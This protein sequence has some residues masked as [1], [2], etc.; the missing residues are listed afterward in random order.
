MVEEPFD[1]CELVGVDGFVLFAVDIMR[2]VHC[3]REAVHAE[4]HWWTT[5]CCQFFHE[6]LEDG[7][8]RFWVRGSELSESGQG[9]VLG[10]GDW[11]A[12]S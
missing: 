11:G 3:V 5:R 9:Y 12:G 6:Y 1:E 8:S 2:V 4:Q 10:N 7:P